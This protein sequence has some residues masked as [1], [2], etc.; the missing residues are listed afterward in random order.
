VTFAE[1]V[2]KAIEGHTFTFENISIQRTASFGVAAWPHPKI[3]S[4]DGLVRAADDALYVA[5]ETGRN[6]VIRFDSDVFN[7]HLADKET[8]PE[9]AEADRR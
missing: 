7:A 4:C 5:K 1:R 2:R 6:R 3:T 9:L 8:A